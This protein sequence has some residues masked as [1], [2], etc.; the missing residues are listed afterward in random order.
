MGTTFIID[1]AAGSQMLIGDEYLVVTQTGVITSSTLAGNGVTAGFASSGPVDIVVEGTIIADAN[2]IEVANSHDGSTVQVSSGGSLFG[3][4]GIFLHLGGAANVSVNGQIIANQRGIDSQSD[5]NS[6]A[7]GSTGTISAGSHGIFSSGANATISNAG[8]ITSFTA[9]MN[10]QGDATSV[11][12]SGTLWGQNNGIYANSMLTFDLT[13]SGGISGD[14]GVRLKD[15]T[16]TSTIIN[17]GAISGQSYSGLYLDNADTTVINTG[18]ISGI[19]TGIKSTSTLSNVFDLDNSGVISGANAA[20]LVDGVVG[21]HVDNSGTLNGDVS[22]TQGDDVLIN[23]GVTNGDVTLGNGAD[24][25]RGIDVGRVSGFVDGGFGNDVLRGGSTGDDLRGG[26][27]NDLLKGH[28]GNDTLDGGTGSDTVSG[29]R[30]DDTVSG[31]NGKDHIR[32]NDGD[33]QLD[34]GKGG[35]ILSGGRGNDALNGGSGKDHLKGGV[36]DDT[37]TGGSSADDFVFSSGGE[38][39]TITDFQDNTDTI[40]LDQSLWGGG[41]TVAEVLNTFATV[42]GTDT[43]FDFGGGDTLVIEGM[44]TVNVIA[45]DILLV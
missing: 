44:A 3:D 28:G 12:N 11:S 22:G 14:T 15:V 37:L 20:I 27:D 25:Y 39:D 41:L 45:D 13:N 4:T 23:S 6:I 42:I 36:G 7:I 9:A 33:D 32:G 17:H 19:G 2:A 8:S 43:V 38:R 34:G 16:G 24:T 31:G 10:I 18:T 21:F 35:D 5:D 30:G 26:D 40:Q 29:G 1:S